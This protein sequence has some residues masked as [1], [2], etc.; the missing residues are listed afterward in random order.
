MK[1]KP[2]NKHK[3]KITKFVVYNVSSKKT[4]TKWK[5]KLKFILNIYDCRFFFACAVSVKLLGY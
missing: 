2:L 4:K 1:A 5:K 3:L